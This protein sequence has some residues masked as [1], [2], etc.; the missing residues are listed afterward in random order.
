MS[1]INKGGRSVSATVLP[2]R[3]SCPKCKSHKV[4]GI[5]YGVPSPEEEA[6]ERAG[7]IVLGGCAFNGNEPRWCCKKCGHEWRG[8]G[9]KNKKSYISANLAAGFG[10]SG[11]GS[12]KGYRKSDLASMGAG[13]LAGS[14]GKRK[15]VK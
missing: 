1:K 8:K 13:A 5:F 2:K 14:Y 15:T 9:K 10:A 11:V 4:C 6:Q 12:T 3:V 7:R